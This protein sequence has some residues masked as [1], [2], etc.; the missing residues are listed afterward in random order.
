MRRGRGK[1][2][3]ENPG[4]C[5]AGVSVPPTAQRNAQHAPRASG[6]LVIVE[7]GRARGIGNKSG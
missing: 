1:R 2:P 4:G 6:E 7:G 3:K 5:D